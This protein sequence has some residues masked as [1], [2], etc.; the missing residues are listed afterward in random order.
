MLREAGANVSVFRIRSLLITSFSTSLEINLKR[1]LA[2]YAI[3]LMVNA[4]YSNYL[5]IKVLFNVYSRS[6]VASQIEI[7]LKIRQPA[8]CD[9]L[10]KHAWNHA[11]QRL[12]IKSPR[13]LHVTAVGCVTSNS[14]VALLFLV[15]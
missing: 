12:A 1:V 2:D 9:H 4:I 14:T 11:Q 7:L 10:K 15:G 6:A 8:A 3:Y 13:L 5:K